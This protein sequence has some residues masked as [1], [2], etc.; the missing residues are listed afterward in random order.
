MHR[1]A[2]GS[3]PTFLAPDSL[4]FLRQSALY[5]QRFDTKRF[6]LVGDAE[7]LVE[8]V[9]GFSASIGTLV[10]RGGSFLGQLTWFDRSG[11]AEGTVGPPDANVL[12]VE[13]SPDETRVAAHR[14]DGSGNLDIWLIDVLRNAMTRLTSD[15]ASD[16]FPIWA[17]DG[18]RAIFDSNRSG[19]ARLYEKAVE[20]AGARTSAGRCRRGEPRGGV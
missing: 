12:S 15:P 11:R 10:Y 17:P 19:G 6:E 20:L 7:R 16:R 9:A 14:D 3:A 8:S 1:L 13:L 2:V 4:L 18:S 5:S